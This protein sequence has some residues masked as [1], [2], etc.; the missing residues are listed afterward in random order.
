M[1]LIGCVVL[2]VFVL[3]VLIEGACFGFIVYCL[4]VW[5]SYCFEYL[6]VVMF[7]CFGFG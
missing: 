5:L 4:C 2:F 6:W 3:I 1:F 7:V